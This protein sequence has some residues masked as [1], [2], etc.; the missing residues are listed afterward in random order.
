MSSMGGTF[1]S[2]HV[3]VG[4]FGIRNMHKGEVNVIGPTSTWTSSG[5]IYVGANNNNTNQPFLAGS[6][7]FSEGT[8]NVTQ[9]G[10]VT[11]TGLILGD[12]RLSRGNVNIDG[13]GSTI[14]VD[15]VRIGHLE[16]FSAGTFGTSFEGDGFLTVSNGGHLEVTGDIRLVAGVFDLNNGSVSAA[17]FF[18]KGESFTNPTQVLLSGNGLIEADVINSGGVISP[19]HS[20]GTLTIN[21]DLTQLVDATLAIELGGLTQG[22]QFDFVQVS[23]AVQLGGT[24]EVSLIDSF[25][26]SA[27]DRFDI[28]DG[29]SFAGALDNVSLAALDSDLGWNLADLYATGELRIELAGDLD[30]DG[31]VGAGDLDLVLAHWGDSVAILNYAQGDASGDGLVGQADLQLVLDHFGNTAASGPV[32]PEPSSFSLLALASIG[33]LRRRRFRGA[34]Q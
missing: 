24:L 28:L 29:A 26:P 12:R 14:T 4:R 30:G 21:G 34:S 31:L 2:R 23:G 25:A 32:I 7:F 19:G 33:C 18:V 17:T 9:G 13:A 1:T 5:A 3:Y 8:V 16:T 20:A 11:A 10:T 15:S 22:S 27:G 6:R